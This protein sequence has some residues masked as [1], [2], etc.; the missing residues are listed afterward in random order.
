MSEITPDTVT[1]SG[2]VKYESAER[3][4]E[5]LSEL[6]ELDSLDRFNNQVVDLEAEEPVIAFSNQ[7]S[8]EY[9]NALTLQSAPSPDQ[10]PEEP[11]DIEENWDSEDFELDT[12]AVGVTF[13]YDQIDLLV[14]LL[15]EILDVVESIE[16]QQFYFSLSLDNQ[17]DDL[18]TISSLNAETEFNLSGVQFEHQNY[19]YSFQETDEGTEGFA[20]FGD[21]GKINKDSVEDFIQQRLEDVVPIIEQICYD[22]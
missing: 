11:P 3:V 14:S 4:L 8:D 10:L 1:F 13:V 2:S 6:K 17:F 9:Q 22:E 15:E 19:L 16:I 21:G 7:V 5:V 20:V 12:L 18:D